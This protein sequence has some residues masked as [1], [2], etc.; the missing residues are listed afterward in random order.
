MNT[1]ETALKIVD[2]WTQDADPHLKGGWS[3]VQ[4]RLGRRGDNPM[5]IIIWPSWKLDIVSF[6]IPE[7][8]PECITDIETCD[9]T[10]ETKTGS[11]VTKTHTRDNTHEFNTM[12]VATVCNVVD[13]FLTGSW[14]PPWTC[15]YCRDR[16]QGQV[17]PRWW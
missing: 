12:P 3:Q 14:T 2:E 1:L 16:K 10:Y 7:T 13:A 17:K 6:L 9:M 11:I 15:G 4:V 8:I 5:A